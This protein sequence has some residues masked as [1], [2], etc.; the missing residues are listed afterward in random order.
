MDIHPPSAP[1][2]RALSTRAKW[3]NFFSL[4]AANGQSTALPYDL[5]DYSNMLS[6]APHFTSC[7][8][9][10]YG[11]LDVSTYSRMSSIAASYGM[12]P[13]DLAQWYLQIQTMCPSYTDMDLYENLASIYHS[14]MS[15]L[16]IPQMPPYQNCNPLADVVSYE[17]SWDV[18]GTSRN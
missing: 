9:P 6:V 13:G 11:H 16:G 2:T 17:L 7:D 14:E 8:V 15:A 12:R 10:W 5:T 1:A 18:E 4:Q 3:H